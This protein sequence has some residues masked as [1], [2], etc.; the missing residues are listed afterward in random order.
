MSNFAFLQAVGRPETWTPS[1]CK[2]GD[3]KR[4][5]VPA[6]GIRFDRQLARNARNLESATFPIQTSVDST[7][8]THIG[9][10]RRVRKAC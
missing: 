4:Q 8:L 5:A 3:A 1:N 2:V 7:R 6:G 9:M 10:A